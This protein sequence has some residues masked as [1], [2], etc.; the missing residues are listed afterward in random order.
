MNVQLGKDTKDADFAFI[1]CSGAKIPAITDQAASL[2]GGQ[3]MITISTK[4]NDA[5]LTD[6]LNNCVFTFKGF[7]SSNCDKTLDNIQTFIDGGNLLQAWTASSRQQS[8][9]WPLAARCE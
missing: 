3:Q 5:G 9:S 6:A 4:G 2:D 8:Q 1:A 7:L